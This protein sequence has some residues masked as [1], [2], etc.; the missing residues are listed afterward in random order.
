MFMICCQK[1]ENLELREVALS[2]EQRKAC[3]DVSPAG[4][5]DRARS[6]LRFTAKRSRKYELWEVALSCGQLTNP[7]SGT[8]YSSQDAC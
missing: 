8:P 1:I 5:R 2:C 4:K 7:G 6:C 3:G